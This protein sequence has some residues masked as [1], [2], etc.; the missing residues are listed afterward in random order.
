MLDMNS[1]EFVVPLL[2]PPLN[3]GVMKWVDPAGAMKMMGR[4]SKQGNQRAFVFCLSLG[5]LVASSA[6]Y[7]VSFFLI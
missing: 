5:S 1:L 2:L 4:K 7:S 3:A 6:A